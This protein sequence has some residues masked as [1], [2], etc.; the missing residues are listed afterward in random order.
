MATSA[1][2]AGAHS[3]TAVYPGDGNFSSRTASPL[4]ETVGLAVTLDGLAT[5]NNRPTLSGAV[6]VPASTGGIPSVV[7]TI[8][9]QKLS[10]VVHGNTWTA[11]VSTALADGVYVAQV[12]ATDKTGKQ[13]TATNSVTVDTAG[14]NVT[15]RSLTTNT[16]K[17]ALGGTWSDASPSSGIAG[18]T[19]VVE[20]DQPERARPPL[21]PD[22]SGD[23]RESLDRVAVPIPIRQS[24]LGHLLA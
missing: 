17:P 10:A 14:P 6:S 15:V 11:L 9:S 21:Q 1:L 12:T 19:V 4:V 5:N 7:V 22:Y 24:R 13:A 3:I 16:S 23:G 18:I 8:N 20:S 2:D